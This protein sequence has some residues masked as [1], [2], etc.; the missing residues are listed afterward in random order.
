MSD[1][2]GTVTVRLMGGP[3]DSQVVDCDLRPGSTLVMPRITD[4]GLMVQDYYLIADDGGS[5]VGN[6]ECT[7]AVPQAPVWPDERDEAAAPDD[8]VLSELNR[9]FKRLGGIQDQLEELREARPAALDPVIVATAAAFRQAAELV[10]DSASTLLCDIASKV[11]GLTEENDM[12]CPVCEETTCDETC[13]LA[14][15]RTRW[16]A[17]GLKEWESKRNE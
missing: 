16:H 7:E 3:L 6:F 9:I 10:H 1:P 5:L 2:I 12:C 14:P 13:P 8:A 15:V 4:E 17:E 11:D